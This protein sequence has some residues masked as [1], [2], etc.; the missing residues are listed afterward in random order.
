[1]AISTTASV[2]VLVAR[3]PLG[4]TICSS[5]ANN[6]F[7]TAR[8]STTLSITRS[9]SASAPRWSVA[10]MR[11]S[12]AARSS[13]VALPRSM[14]FTKPLSMVVTI[15]LAASIERDRT[16]T[17]YPARAATSAKPEPMMPEP[18][19]PTC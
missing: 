12:T 19:T 2:L 1:M 6:A 13:S 3:M 18:K 8:S 15:A 4:L 7:F 14:A 16:M 10:V 11:A 5:S 17:L 9:Q